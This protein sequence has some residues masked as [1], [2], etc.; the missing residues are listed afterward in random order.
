V[1]CDTESDLDQER[2]STRGHLVESYQM[3]KKD[4]KLKQEN[5]K[6]FLIHAMRTRSVAGYIHSSLTWALDGDEWSTSPSGHFAFEK[7]SW[8]GGWVGF[9]SGPDVSLERSIVFLTPPRIELRIVQPVAWKLY[10]LCCTGV[11][12]CEVKVLNNS[13]WWEI[14]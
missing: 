12:Q 11:M 5:S 2:L 14:L 9:V 6:C 10:S 1:T 8:V 13:W 3:N 7:K 4:I